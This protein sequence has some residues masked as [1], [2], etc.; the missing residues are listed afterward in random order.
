MVDDRRWHQRGVSTFALLEA[1]YRRDGS[2]E[3]NRSRPHW[4]QDVPTM[5]KPSRDVA[6]RQRCCGSGGIWGRHC[7]EGHRRR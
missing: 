2:V 4:R 5:Y 3:L 6:S 1:S 7:A